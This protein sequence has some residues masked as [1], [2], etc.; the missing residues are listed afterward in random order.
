MTNAKSV[1]P[2]ETTSQRSR[3]M[4]RVRRAGTAPE[5]MLRKELHKAGLRY[6]LDGGRGLPGTP[7]L[8]FRASKVAIFVDGCFWHGCPKHGTRPKTNTSF[9][10]AKISRNRERDRQVGQELRSQGWRVFRFCERQLM[11]DLPRV[12]A[13]ITRAVAERQRCS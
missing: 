5:L 8:V 2:L 10:T 11:R 9:W 13:V 7:D 6:R 12:V 3:L 4:A 1:L